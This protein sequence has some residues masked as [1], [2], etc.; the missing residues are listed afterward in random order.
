LI[1]SPSEK[2][3]CLEGNMAHFRKRSGAWEATVQK[4]GI[5][6]I[7]RTFDT[8]TDAEAWAKITES[9]LV[10]G[11]FIPR[12]E[13]E[14]TTLSEAL[15]RYE[16]EVS[17]AKKG[18]RREKTRI[19]LWKTH[20][21]AKRVLAGIRG[22]DL[23]TYRD[24]RL[25]AGYSANT[26]RLELAIIS[27]LFEIARKEWGMEGLHNPVKAIRIPSAPPGRDRRLFLGELE[28]IL[29]ASRSPHLG[30]IVRFALET[31]MRRGEIAGMTWE[32]VDLKRRTVTLPETKNGEKRTV[33]LSRE[34]VQILSS[35]PRRIDGRVW[36]MG[37]DSI[38]Q[39]FAKAVSLAR[40]TYVK[41]FEEKHKREKNAKPDP[42]FL[43][44]LTFHDLRHEAT[45]RLF[46]KGFNPMEVS[47]ITGHK[48]L[49]MLKRYTHLRAEDLVERM[50]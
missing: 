20:T 46:E 4:K 28:K 32:M 15:D 12:K 22:N 45:S 17:S 40:E 13:A 47:T 50:K 11:V 38:S 26:V 30:D 7:S 18:H 14:S 25:K 16:K 3:L 9:E 33:P 1:R 21:L 19:V 29:E 48:T 42:A 44:D 8:R 34:A 24:E 23:A 41:D 10:R 39:D 35:I 31:A 37:P 6:R 2:V 43:V 36:G 49:Q 5:G 27:H